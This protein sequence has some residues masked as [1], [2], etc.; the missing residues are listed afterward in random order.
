MKILRKVVKVNKVYFEKLLKD[1]RIE[2]KDR[3]LLEILKEFFYS[4]KF[5]FRWIIVFLNWL[6]ML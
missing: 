4:K 6:V 5:I 3:G 2:K 1:F